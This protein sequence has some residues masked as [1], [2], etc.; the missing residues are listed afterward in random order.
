MGKQSTRAGAKIPAKATTKIGDSN[1]KKTTISKTS[2]TTKTADAT[3]TS[4]ASKNTNATA[5]NPLPGTSDGSVVIPQDDSLE[6]RNA[7][8]A[9]TKRSK[10]TQ[11]TVESDSSSSS[12]DDSD[13]S[14][15]SS[16]DCDSDATPAKKKMTKR[17]YKEAKLQLEIAKLKL[18]KTRAKQQK[19]SLINKKKKKMPPPLSDSDDDQQKRPPPRADT[20]LNFKTY[21]RDV[22]DLRDI[23]GGSSPFE[24]IPDGHLYG[25]QAGALTSFYSTKIGDD[26]PRS[27]RQKIC[28]QEY[29]DFVELLTC[30]YGMVPD[31]SNKDK[32][33]FMSF[34]DWQF[35]FDSFAFC[36]AKLHALEGAE[37]ALLQDMFTYKKAVFQLYERGDQWIKYD[38]LFRYHQSLKPFPWSLTRFD[39]IWQCGKE[40]KKGEKPPTNQ[41]PNFDQNIKFG[42][43]RRYHSVNSRCPKNSRD[44]PYNHRCQLCDA[45][46][47]LYECSKN[48]RSS[49]YDVVTPINYSNLDFLL[50]QTKYDTEKSNFLVNGFKNG[51][52]LG[53]TGALLNNEVFSMHSD[54]LNDILTTKIEEEL[55]LGRIGGPFETP[56]FK[57]YQVSPIFLREKSVAGKYRMILDL[58]HPK[59]SS[60]IN[61]NIDSS[62]KSV[63]YASV[64][65][66]IKKIASLKKGSYTCK[67]DIKDAFRLLPIHPDDQNKLCFTHNNLYYYEKVL[68]Q[69]SGSSCFL[70][71]A[72]STAI[73][74]IFSHFAPLCKVVH[75][76]DDFIFIAPTYDLCLEYQNMFIKICDQLG[77][78][79]SPH[80]V[81]KPAQNTTFLG[82]L[83]DSENHLA[84]LP[85][86]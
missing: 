55:K 22:P 9:G 86:D 61:N 81:T 24:P 47:P 15:D 30:K 65:D 71:E 11:P 78:P 32:F 74:H 40:D 56:P 58:S 39:L 60:S 21:S 41:P 51:F 42:Y 37:Y 1:A 73:E 16:S 77:V 79:L 52:K 80:K 46:H 4:D 6:Q 10:N 29:V 14:S 75:Y 69:G 43:C 12:S 38:K 59:N 25:L 53:H 76:L 5:K 70:F 64:R 54:K 19:A 44:C 48:K 3:L 2:K 18:K 27:I 26:L 23:V 8:A 7:L 45:K 20:A 57:H 31:Y 17:S 36:Y 49:K 35:C 66:A 82:I 83:L 63:Q 84:K 50:K 85:E 62:S 28:K 33:K 68:P 72:F 34:I 13:S 67:I